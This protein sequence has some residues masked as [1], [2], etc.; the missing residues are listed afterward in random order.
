[1]A[2]C[3]I[4]QFATW[5]ALPSA[6]SIFHNVGFAFGAFPHYAS[7]SNGALFCILVILLALGWQKPSI[8]LPLIFVVGGGGSNILDRIMFG[9]VRDP[10]AIGTWQGNFADIC[11]GI[12]IILLCVVMYTKR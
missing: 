2:V 7:A 6:S 12:G 8:R 3:A 10:V 5:V 9:F 4:S 11:M 1:M